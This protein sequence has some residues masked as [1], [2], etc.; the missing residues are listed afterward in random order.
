M[1][2]ENDSFVKQMNKIFD[3]NKDNKNEELFFTFKGVLYP[4]RLCSAETF[5]ALE[6]FEARKDDMLLI[7]Y[8][9]CGTN[10]VF[11]ILIEMVA[12]I[13]SNKELPLLRHLLVL[14]FGSPEKF[15]MLVVFRNPKDAATSY[16]HFYN[17]NPLLPT[18][19]AWKSYFDHALAW[20]KHMD[21]ENVMIITYE[22]LKE[23]SLLEIKLI[24]V[25]HIHFSVAYSYGGNLLQH[26]PYEQ[27]IHEQIG[28]CGKGQERCSHESYH[29]RSNL[30]PSKCFGMLITP[31][32]SFGLFPGEVGDWRTLFTEAQS[33]EMDAK[34]EACLAGTKL[35][36]KLKYDKYCK[37]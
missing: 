32:T 6:T 30:P 1:A 37:F 4:N 11:Q 33:K 27:L 19:I 9:K 15:L 23:V 7:A 21:E 16:Y 35:G 24:F 10:W 22:E 29:H 8:P 17:K 3:E 34:F 12:A 26:S 5:E 28:I 2:E 14:E 36:A 31:I 13:S 25:L 20:D 18:P